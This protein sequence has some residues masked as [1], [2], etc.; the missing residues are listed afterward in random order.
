MKKT[1]IPSVAWVL[2]GLLVIAAGLMTL[3]QRD[4]TTNPSATSYGPSGTQIFTEVLRRQGLPVVV[5]LTSRPQM[6]PKDL[7]VCFFVEQTVSDYSTGN[8]A[9]ESFRPVLSEHL[10]NGGRAV[11]LPIS[12]EFPRISKAAVAAS[13]ATVVPFGDSSRKL[14]VTN[15]GSDGTS[16]FVDDEIA[17]E[18]ESLALWSGTTGPAATLNQ[19]GKGMAVY[20]PSGLIATNRFID[21]ENNAEFLV[22]VIRSVLPSG[23]RVVISEASFGGASEPGLMESIGPWAEGAWKQI[24]FLFVVIVY[25]LGKRFGLPEMERRKQRGQ[26]ELLDA[27]AD[28]YTRAKMGGIALDATYKETDAELRRALKLPSEAKTRDRNDRLPPDLVRA[29][30]NVEMN[31]D[32]DLKPD[33]A[34]DLCIAMERSAKEF[35]GERK[36]PRGR[37]RNLR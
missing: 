31:L 32:A 22:S 36:I 35:L 14:R 11:I 28:T 9:T 19:Y 17:P 7:L 27:V 10:K 6:N 30:T 8:P 5:D 4:T 33:A 23:G 24:L 1:G 13:P 15:A 21:R 25:T 3:G 37:P 26:R 29:L 12:E 34:L 16:T 18:G 20:L 2:L